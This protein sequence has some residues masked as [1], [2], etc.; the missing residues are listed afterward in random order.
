[1]AKQASL[2]TAPGTFGFE[3]VES[4]FI[5]INDA[6]KAEILIEGRVLYILEK[7]LKLFTYLGCFDFRPRMIKGSLTVSNHPIF[8]AASSKVINTETAEDYTGSLKAVI[9]Y[10]LEKGMLYYRESDKLVKYQ[11][12]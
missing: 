10:W 7:R 5:L 11:S 2:K 3:Y 4:N 1:M 8:G 6:N 9:K 12:T